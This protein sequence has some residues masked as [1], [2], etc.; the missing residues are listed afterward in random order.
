MRVYLV[1]EFHTKIDTDA[2]KANK[3]EYKLNGQYEKIDFAAAGV[4]SAYMAEACKP[5]GTGY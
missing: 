3:F 2:A 5:V 4:V 1:I